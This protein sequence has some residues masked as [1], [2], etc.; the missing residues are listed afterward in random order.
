MSALPTHHEVSI[1]ADYHQ[2]YALDSWAALE[3]T[4]NADFWTREAFVRMLAVN[5]GIFG[6]GTAT[7][8]EV[9]VT[10]HVDQD[11][12]RADLAGW[13]HVVEVDLQLP[14]GQL[15]VCGCTQ[16][17]EEGLHLE[18][19]FGG[20]IARVCYGGLDS[21]V[22]EAGDDHYSIFMWPAEASG[23][24]VLKQWPKRRAPS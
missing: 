6:V 11:A 20:Y 12:P 1:Y 21:V 13:D 24:R 8:G 4:D 23:V 22:D 10:L 3:A 5:P 9:P 19:P 7:A 17:R 16:P 18:L 15:I 2:F 14:S